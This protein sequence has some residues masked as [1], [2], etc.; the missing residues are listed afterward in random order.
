MSTIVTMMAGPNKKWKSDWTY[1]IRDN[2]IQVVDLNCG[3]M[4]VTNDAEAVVEELNKRVD[5]KN[6]IIQYIDSTGRIDRLLHKN[7]VFE[8]FGFGPWVEVWE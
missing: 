6:K 7:G 8:K 4:S 2:V 5:L 1:E 3:G